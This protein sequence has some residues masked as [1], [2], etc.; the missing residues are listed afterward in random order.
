MSETAFETYEIHETAAT[1]GETLT[2]NFL[3]HCFGWTIDVI[4][5]SS[6]K[7][8]VLKAEWLLKNISLICSDFTM[9][10]ES[11][12]QNWRCT[13]RGLQGWL[14]DD[15][16]RWREPGS[17]YSRAREDAP[18]FFGKN[19]ISFSVEID[20]VPITFEQALMQ[21]VLYAELLRQ[22]GLTDE[23]VRDACDEVSASAI[24]TISYHNKGAE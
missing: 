19:G 9:D 11:I 24:V 1:D 8:G 13:V 14:N 5:K 10:Y 20:D 7:K 23:E 3:E 4:P 15:H 17:P 18:F 12:R 6:L 2:H 21:A 16:Q 22:R